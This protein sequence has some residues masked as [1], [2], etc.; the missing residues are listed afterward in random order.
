M[1]RFSL[2]VLL[3]VLAVVVINVALLVLESPEDA[4]RQVIADCWAES[5]SSS[6]TQE[7]RQ[8]VVDACRALER[9]F[10]VNHGIKLTPG[11]GEV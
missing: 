4:D 6:L 11:A 9:V 8:I 7:K 2:L 5:R 10:M 3:A 1:K